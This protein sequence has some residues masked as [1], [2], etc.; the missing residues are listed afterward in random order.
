M[1]KPLEILTIGHSNRPWE[2]FIKILNAHKIDKVIDI[3]T[4][5]GSRKNPQFNRD[6]L[7]EGLM[8]ARIA[9]DHMDGLGGLRKPH[10]DSVNTGWQNASFRGF[11]DY[12]Q[13]PEFEQ[14]LIELI[15]K[16]KDKRIVIMCAEAV[17]W[18][19]HRLLIADALIIRG[20]TVGHIISKTQVKAHTLTPW[21]KAD[22]IKITYP[23]N[24]EDTL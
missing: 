16:A 21:A 6:S 19:C 4:I 13:T 20:I 9:Y 11:A 22:G 12:M 24:K 10:K 17:P 23:G 15:N 7:S 1:K 3:R 2:V 14:C 18:R 5:P 8:K